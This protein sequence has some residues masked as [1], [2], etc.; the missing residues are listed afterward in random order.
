VADS[1]TVVKYGTVDERG[2]WV[3]DR[4]AVYFAE[5]LNSEF[6]LQVEQALKNLKVSNNDVPD[7]ERR[8]V[9][10]TD[11][12][13][14]TQV[15]TFVNESGQTIRVEMIDGEPWFV[16]KDV[17]DV[18]DIEKYRDAIARLDDDEKG[19]PLLMDTPGGKQ[20]L[21]AVN[22]SG[23]YN[24]IFQS[25]KPEAKIFRK[26]VTSEVLPTIRR[27]GRY[28]ISRKDSQNIPDLGKHL[29][30][31]MYDVCFIED[32]NLRTRIAEQLK[33]LAL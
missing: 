25:R 9:G 18:L 17:C 28:S 8:G 31:I 6:S 29:S 20:Q 11:P 27:T 26:W 32:I 14:G 5:W 13:G 30:N 2:T 1:W 33:N 12:L 21:S 15:A 4:L 22:E 16:A 7:T 23:L 24:L 3:H 19:C 10:T